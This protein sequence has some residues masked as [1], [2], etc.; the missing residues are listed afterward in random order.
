MKQLSFSFPPS[1]IDQVIN[2]MAAQTLVLH[3]D[4]CT[5]NFIMYYEPATDMWTMLPWDLDSAFGIDRGLGGEPTKDY[6]ILACERF[7]TPLYC[8]RN[9]P[10]D[11]VSAI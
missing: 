5:K 8:D 3:Q 4:R 2:L 6:C 1:Y 7:N 9:H 10:Q 11:I